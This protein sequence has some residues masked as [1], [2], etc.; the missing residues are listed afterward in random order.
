MNGTWN[1]NPIYNGFDDPAFENDMAALKAETEK[2][3]AFAQ[4]LPTMEAAEGLK[5]G[6]A[7]QERFMELGNKLGLYAS[8]RQATNTRDTEAGSRMG[9]S[10]SSTAVW[11]PP[12]LRSRIGR[13]RSPI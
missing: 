11:P 12:L 1:L 3:A 13:P 10:C 6:I 7:L 4:A 2:I 8:L 5:Q 9:R